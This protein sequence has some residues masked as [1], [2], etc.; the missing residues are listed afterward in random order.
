MPKDES[1]IY[2]ITA[3]DSDNKETERL[4]QAESRAAALK[5]VVRLNKASAAD[6]ARVMASGASVEEAK[7]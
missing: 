6:V 4:V 1:A 3:F 7:E 5:H 2:L